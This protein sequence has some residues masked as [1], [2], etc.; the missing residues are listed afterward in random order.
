MQRQISTRP[1]GLVSSKCIEQDDD[2]DEFLTSASSSA[3][4]ES[5]KHKQ[6]SALALSAAAPSS[7]SSSAVF[8]KNSNMVS[9]DYSLSGNGNSNSSNNLSGRGNINSNIS[10]NFNISSTT[11]ITTSGGLSSNNAMNIYGTLPKQH[12]SLPSASSSGI[13]TSSDITSTDHITSSYYKEFNTADGGNNSNSS[14]GV[15]SMAGSTSS[16]DF[17]TQQRSRPGHN[18]NTIGTYKVQYSST[19]PFFDAIE[20][21]QMHYAQRSPYNFGSNGDDYDDLK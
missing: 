5:N 10:S 9:P 6:H 14:S 2:S 13:Y 21:Q 8:S 11:T 4:Y 1:K 16:Y 17:Y 19:N 7:S 20:P 3:A 12:S 15:S 18:Y